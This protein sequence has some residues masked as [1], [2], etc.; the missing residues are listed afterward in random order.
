MPSVQGTVRVVYRLGP[1]RATNFTP[2]PGKDTV[3][4]PGQA[5]GLSTFEVIRLGR[6]DKAQVIDLALLQPPL[7]A[8]PDDPGADGTPGHVS[9]VPVDDTGAVDQQLLDAWAS[10]RI[11]SS[12]HP[13]TQIVMDAVVQQDL[14]GPP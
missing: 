1:F 2:R 4:R 3:G 10:W 11:Q 14:K 9:I 12:I 6:K 13:L 5:P 7:Q 8:I